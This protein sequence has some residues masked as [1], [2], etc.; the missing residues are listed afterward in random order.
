MVLMFSSLSAKFNFF[1]FSDIFSSAFKHWERY[2]SFPAVFDSPTVYHPIFVLP[3]T[4]N[5]LPFFLS[6]NLSVKNYC[7]APFPITLQ[8]C[9]Q[10]AFLMP[11]PMAIFTM[12]VG[13]T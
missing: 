5:S 11:Y 8:N 7:L 1:H 12:H 13:S 10:V 6:G 4:A 3:F 9:S 2:L